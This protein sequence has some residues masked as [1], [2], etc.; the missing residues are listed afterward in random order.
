MLGGHLGQNVAT[1]VGVTGEGTW[2]PQRQHADEALDLVQHGTGVGQALTVFQPR[3]VH[4]PYHSVQLGLHFGWG[5]Q[6]V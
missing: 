4:P 3:S 6:R 1:Q 5:G 2:Q